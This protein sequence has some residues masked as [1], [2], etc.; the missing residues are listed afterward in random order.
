MKNRVFDYILTNLLAITGNVYVSKKNAYPS[1]IVIDPSVLIV[2]TLIWMFLGIFF[3]GT[4]SASNVECVKDMTE[5]TKFWYGIKLSSIGYFATY[6]VLLFIR[7]FGTDAC[8][9]YKVKGTIS[10]SYKCVPF[11]SWKS[12]N[13]IMN[14]DLAED[15]EFKKAK[16]I[17]NEKELENILN[18]IINNKTW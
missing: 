18:N 5:N 14:D 9:S 17:D 16:H 7:W 3:A 8:S 6:I 10:K 13:T 11:I 15:R 4:L 12:Y 2:F 1:R